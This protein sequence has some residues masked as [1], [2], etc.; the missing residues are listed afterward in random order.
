MLTLSWVS[1]IYYGFYFLLLRFDNSANPVAIR[2]HATKNS[3]TN[4]AVSV[5]GMQTKAAR[6]KA[7]TVIITASVVLITF[8]S[9]VHRCNQTIIYC[10]K[11]QVKA[12]FYG[13]S[14][15]QAQFTTCQ[16]IFAIL[17]L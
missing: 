12:D 8:S 11:L 5:N 10:P 7:I 15:C 13:F 14:N 2:N 4:S 6:K 9:S 16:T 17:C 1:A 3:G